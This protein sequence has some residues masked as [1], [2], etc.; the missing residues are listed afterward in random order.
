MTGAS[1]LA[2]PA[3]RKLAGWWRQLAPYHP[4]KIWVGH[5]VLHHVE[6]LVRSSQ[7]R[8][9][10]RISHFLLKALALSEPAWGSSPATLHH[11]DTRLHLG[12]QMLH[13]ALRALETEKLA[14]GGP[15]G[16]WTLTSLGRQALEHREYPQVGYQRHIFHFIDQGSEAGQTHRLQFLDLHNSTGISWPAAEGVE[17]DVGLLQACLRQSENWKRKHGFPLDAQEILALESEAPANPALGT[18]Q[19][20]S[21]QRVV[22]DRPERVLALL[23]A[24]RGSDGTGQLLALAIRQDGWLLQSG[25]PLFR[26]GPGWREFFPDLTV[27]PALDAWRQTWRAWCEPRGIPA[28]EIIACI[29]ERQG[30]RLRV[31]IPHHLMERL[32]ATRSDALK[33][34]TWL[35]AGEGPIRPAVL[36]EVVESRPR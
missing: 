2:F 19:P 17:F 30:E 11:L 33:G 20:P 22:V 16:N 8:R 28:N 3:S 13:Q 10:D 31:M 4:E 21:W 7:A 26:L 29:L 24:A 1:S 14:Q 12:R 36:V 25:I 15:E 34:E 6:A 5:L 35:L 23:L 32:R 27:E 18:E 9:L